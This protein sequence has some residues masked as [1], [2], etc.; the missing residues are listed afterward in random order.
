MLR[1]DA[2]IERLHL[3]RELLVGHFGDP[4]AGLDVIALSDRQRGDGAAD[5]GARDKLMDGLDGGD[6]RLAVVDIGLAYDEGR[7]GR[8]R[9]GE[10]KEEREASHE[11]SRIAD[12]TH[13]S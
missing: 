12:L 2:R 8:R 13:I 11:G 3:Q 6:H 5:A 4:L 7:R 1:S 9:G 10:K